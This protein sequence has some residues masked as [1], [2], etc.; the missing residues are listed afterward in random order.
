MTRQVAEA[1]GRRGAQPAGAPGA[2]GG[3]DGRHP[4]G[5]RRPRPGRLVQLAD[6]PRGRPAPARARAATGKDVVFS[7]VGRRGVST[8]RFRGEEL[9]GEY[10]GFTDRPAFANAREIAD[11]L[12]AAL[13]RRGARP[14]RADLQPLRLAAHPVRAGG[15]RCSRSSRP[16]SSARAS[17]EDAT[18]PRRTTRTW[19]RRTARR[20]GTTSPSPRSCSPS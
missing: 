4:A 12:I 5:H 19:P 11:E 13:R 7:V 3:E 14:G 18:R 17:E 20:S 15:R 2:R 6:H 9:H 10:V 1:A 16:R 8:M